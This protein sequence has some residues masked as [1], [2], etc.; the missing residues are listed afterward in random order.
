[1]ERTRKIM[2]RRLPLVQIPEGADVDEKPLDVEDIKR[3]AYIK[4]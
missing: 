2:E 4:E 3:K 1:M